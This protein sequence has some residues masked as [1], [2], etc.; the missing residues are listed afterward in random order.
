V[1]FEKIEGFSTCSLVL[2]LREPEKHSNTMTITYR[3]YT[4]QYGLDFK[5][6]QEE[7]VNW[8]IEKE[9]KNHGGLIADEMGLGK[10]Y[11]C[12]ALM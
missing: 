2:T 4:S 6:Y 1:G 3:E 8:C 5:E 9:K 10:T 11:Q 7:C 12:I